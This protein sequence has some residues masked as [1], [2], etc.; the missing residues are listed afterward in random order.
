MAHGTES[1]LTLLE[2][3][4]LQQKLWAPACGFA[5]CLYASLGLVGAHKAESEAADDG[6]VLGPVTGPVAR[7]V[8]AEFDIEQPMHALDAPMAARAPGDA[9]DVERGGRDVVADVEAT[10]IGVF[11]ACMDLD[12][13][14]DVLE[15][16]LAWIAS[17]GCN[18]VDLAGGGVGARLDPAMALLDDGLFAD[19][20]VGRGGAEI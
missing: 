15:A 3:Q 18:P 16:R 20:L 14:L 10:A 8:V 5:A 19:E 1:G 12:D 11:N 6:H 4:D 7:Q 17:L 2:L 13:G 9:F